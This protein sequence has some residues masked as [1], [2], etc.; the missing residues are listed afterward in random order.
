M[1]LEWQIH[2]EEGILHKR[3]RSLPSLPGGKWLDR[4]SLA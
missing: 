3:D 4:L 2:Y 1:I